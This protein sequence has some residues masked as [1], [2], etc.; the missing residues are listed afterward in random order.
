MGFT[1]QPWTPL[2]NAA[3]TIPSYKLV[4]ELYDLPPYIW[5]EEAAI[6]AVSTFGTYI[7]SIAPSDLADQSSW[8]AVVATE[9]QR[10]PQNVII[11]IGGLEHTIAIRS[12]KWSHVLL[13]KPADL[14]Q[15]PIRYSR[16]DTS[17]FTDASSSREENGWVYDEPICISQRAL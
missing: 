14:P 15:L 13:Y 12:I 9:L 1:F 10:V 7:G 16:L 3:I 2:E 8:L 5:R 4:V 11:V 17:S 6:Q